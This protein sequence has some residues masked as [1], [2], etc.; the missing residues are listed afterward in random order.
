M[1]AKRAQYNAEKSQRRRYCHET[2]CHIV[3]LHLLRIGDSG[4]YNKLTR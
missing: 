1:R 2:P 3:F 4:F